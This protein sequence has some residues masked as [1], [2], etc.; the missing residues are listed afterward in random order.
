MG[1][2]AVPKTPS[3]RLRLQVYLTPEADGGY[4]AVAAS[5][6]G[7]VSQ[8]ET[9][10]EAL[11]N[12]REAFAGV[13]AAYREQRMAVPWLPEPEEPESGAITRWVEVDG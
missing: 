7:C 12:I 2:A 11:A 4:S 5:L 9:E 1:M 8:G 3:G 6:P 10:A 13:L